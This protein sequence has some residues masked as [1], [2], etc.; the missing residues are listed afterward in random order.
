MKG[1]LKKICLI[2]VYM[3]VYVCMYTHIVT[4]KSVCNF[5]SLVTWIYSRIIKATSNEFKGSTTFTF[6]M[7]NM[8]L[9]KEKR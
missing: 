7:V 2:C 9:A 5:K 3:C 1:K 8:T 4:M 6:V